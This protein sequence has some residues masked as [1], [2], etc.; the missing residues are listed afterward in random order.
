[1]KQK[2]RQQN[3]KKLIRQEG[4]IDLQ[5]TYRF[6]EDRDTDKQ[7]HRETDAII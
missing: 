2:D 3:I 5:K 1:M 6:T 4:K 7:R